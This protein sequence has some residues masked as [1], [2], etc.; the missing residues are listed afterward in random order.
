LANFIEYS[1]AAALNAQF[2][3]DVAQRLREGITQ[4][5]RASLVVSGGKTPLEFFKQLSRQ[6]LD[7]QNVYITLADERWVN[8]NDDASNE[9]TVRASLLQYEAATANFIG[10]KTDGQNPV[11]DAIETERV[12]K[13][14]PMPFDVLILGMGDDG[15]TASLFPGAKNLLPALAMDSG[16]LC[17][18]MTPLTAPHDRITLTLPAILNSRHIYLHIVGENKKRVYQQA[19]TGVDV[20]EMPVRAVLQQSD[21]P[22]DVI[23]AP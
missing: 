14:M 21:V 15:H 19:Q 16:R 3:A 18:A 7:W 17:M 22:V 11:D 23:W 4:N 9:K 1:S 12:I 2:A 20:N 6:T 13:Q 8:V 10:L 5:G